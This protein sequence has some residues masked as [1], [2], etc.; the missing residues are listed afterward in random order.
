MTPHCAE[1]FF[2]HSWHRC[3]EGIYCCV[4]CWV[5]APDLETEH[6]L[7]WEDVPSESASPAPMLPADPRFRYEPPE[8]AVAALALLAGT[9]VSLEG[10]IQACLPQ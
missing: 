10:L 5:I 9:L 8:L 4:R 1:G 6:V 7:K 2:Y 3:L